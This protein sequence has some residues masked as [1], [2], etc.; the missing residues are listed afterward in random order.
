M[1]VES[2][3]R[4]VIVDLFEVVVECVRWDIWE[5]LDD[6][7]LDV[8]VDVDLVLGLLEDMIVVL[9]KFYVMCKEWE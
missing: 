6:V 7:E 1:N 2:W 5:Y 8:G 4:I 3:L 9:K